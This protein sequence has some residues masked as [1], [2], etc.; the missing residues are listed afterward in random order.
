MLLRNC[1][2]PLLLSV[3]SYVGATIAGCEL[4]L[5]DVSVASHTYKLR[6]CR[7]LSDGYL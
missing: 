2:L 7:G 5:G 6:C 1:P 3:I 4:L